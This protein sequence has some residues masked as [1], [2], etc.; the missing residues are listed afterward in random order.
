MI[1][2]TDLSLCLSTLS[3]LVALHFGITEGFWILLG[4]L[5]ARVRDERRP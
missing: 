3:L 5:L 1:S 4:V 2:K